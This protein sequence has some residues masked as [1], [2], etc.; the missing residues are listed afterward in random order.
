MLLK[1]LPFLYMPDYYILC[2]GLIEKEGKSGE[3]LNKK[4]FFEGLENKV[5]KLEF[6]GEYYYLL[7]KIYMLLR[8]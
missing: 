4:I 8:L 2:K 5:Y 1:H 7:I 3:I 6:T